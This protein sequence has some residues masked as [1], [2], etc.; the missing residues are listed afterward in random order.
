MAIKIGDMLVK[1]DIIT[2]AQL[3]EGLRQQVIYGGKLGTNLIEMGVIDEEALAFFL[4]EKLGVPYVHPSQFENIPQK[5]IDIIPKKIVEKHKVFPVEVS[6]KRLSLVMADPTD[7]AVIDEISFLVNMQIK[8]VVAPEI[9]LTMAFEKYYGIEKDL[10]YISLRNTTDVSLTTETT[11][12]DI[13]ALASSVETEEDD[14]L[15]DLEFLTIDEEVEPDV[16]GARTVAIEE[17]VVRKYTVDDI[18]MD[19][20]RS[21]DREEVAQC[22]IDYIN[23][24]FSTAAIFVL[25]DKFAVGWKASGPS[26]FVEMVS[27]MKLAIS[28]HMPFKRVHASKQCYLGP[29]CNSPLTNAHNASNADSELIMPIIMGNEVVSF[30]Y[31]CGAEEALKEALLEYNSIAVKASLAFEMLVIKNKIMMT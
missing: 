21:E 31:V 9:R 13:K 5:V 30:L 15:D 16:E 20:A 11:A 2:M 4:S 8:P 12:K 23:Q 22:V 19:M 28:D 17:E 6:K 3:D 1:A 29:C 26:A 14:L 10:R 27:G 18:S 25:W 7:M 24:K